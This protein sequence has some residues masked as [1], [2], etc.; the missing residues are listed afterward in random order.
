MKVEHQ[1]TDKYVL[2]TGSSPK[3]KILHSGDWGRAAIDEY[4]HHG[5]LHFWINT[6]LV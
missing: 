1:Y 2:Y 5:R 4:F 6:I 3:A